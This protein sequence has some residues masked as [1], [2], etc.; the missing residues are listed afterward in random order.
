MSL[1]A[2]GDGA[3]ALDSRSRGAVRDLLFVMMRLLPEFLRLQLGTPSDL[4]AAH[5]HGLKWLGI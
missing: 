1:S 5:W 2:R 3:D 4:P